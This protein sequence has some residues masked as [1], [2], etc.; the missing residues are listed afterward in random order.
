MAATYITR[1]ELLRR[2]RNDVLTLKDIHEQAR[3]YEQ[4]L[5]AAN[6]TGVSIGTEVGVLLTLGITYKADVLFPENTGYIELI[7]WIYRLD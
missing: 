2:L 7:Y 1:R 3:R 6:L 5:I 4:D